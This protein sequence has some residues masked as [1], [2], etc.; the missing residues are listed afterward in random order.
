MFWFDFWIVYKLI[1]SLTHKATIKARKCNSKGYIDT[2]LRRHI[3]VKFVIVD[4]S[5]E[6]NVRPIQALLN[7]KVLYWR[8]LH[9]TSKIKHVPSDIFDPNWLPIVQNSNFLFVLRK[10]CEGVQRN[11]LLVHSHLWKIRV[12]LIFWLF[13]EYSEFPRFSHLEKT[14]HEDNRC[15]QLPWRNSCLFS[16]GGI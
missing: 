15:K 5:K 11:F 2:Y 14:C 12:V 8:A 1:G 9:S 7:D 4:F 10:L 6:N 13:D 3:K 16:F